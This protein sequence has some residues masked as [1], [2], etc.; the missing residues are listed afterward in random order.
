MTR[1]FSLPMTLSAPPKICRAAFELIGRETG[2]QEIRGEDE[3]VALC[4]DH[5]ADPAQDA[6]KHAL[7]PR[8]RRLRNCFASAGYLV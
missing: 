6:T 7:F 3:H 8:R 5:A 1:S 2:R 4:A